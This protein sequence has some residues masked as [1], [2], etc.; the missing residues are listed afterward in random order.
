MAAVLDG[1]RSA[2][3]PL[4]S[5]VKFVFEGEDGGSPHLEEVLTRNKDLLRG[6]VWLVCDGPTSF[7]PPPS[8]RPSQSSRIRLASA[9][10][11]A[12]GKTVE[13]TS[14]LSF[15]VGLHVER[16]LFRVGVLDDCEILE[17]PI[18]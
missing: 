16:G 11:H 1:L 15:A 18:S 2:H 14:A 17:G 4:C 12:S 3:V 7:F 6:D 9:S 10:G 5:N 8:V 13:E